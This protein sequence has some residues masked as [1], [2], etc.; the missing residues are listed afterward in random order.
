MNLSTL[1]SQIGD[2]TRA[3]GEGL[4][5]ALARLDPRKWFESKPPSKQLAFTLAFVG[6]AAKMAKADGVAVAVETEAFER[7]FYVP[8]EERANVERVYRL[9][10]QDV[11]GYEIYAERMAKLLADDPALLRDVFECL[12]NIA[13]ADGVLHEGE[14]TFLRTVA[15]KFGYDECDYRRIR[16]LFVRD[17]ESPY[18]VLGVEPDI[19][20]EDL[21]ARRRQLARENHPDALAAQG[22]P[23]E[24]LVLAD[25][26]L[27]AINAAYDAIMKERGRRPREKASG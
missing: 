4:A 16:S 23:E 25:R 21:N 19:S 15:E 26:K 8:P 7:C 27:A 1:M 11:A 12:F 22:V 6:L 9:A 18:E 13:A 24:F 10:A 2:G 5:K 14:E 3:L 20:D 17:P